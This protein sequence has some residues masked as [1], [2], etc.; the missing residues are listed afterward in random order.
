M[1]YRVKKNLEQWCTQAYTF[2]K[3]ATEF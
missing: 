1:R 3:N 2:G